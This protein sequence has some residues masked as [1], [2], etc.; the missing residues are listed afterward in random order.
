[1]G[2]LSRKWRN[3]L[4]WLVGIFSLLILMMVWITSDILKKQEVALAA[5]NDFTEVIAMPDLDGS[6]WW[7]ITL[8]PEGTTTDL[9]VINRLS[10]QQMIDWSSFSITMGS[11]T[12][13]NFL[14]QQTLT[15]NEYQVTK[16]HHSYR[17]SASRLEQVWQ[18]RYRVQSSAVAAQLVNQ[19]Q[20]SGKGGGLSVGSP[21]SDQGSFNYQAPAASKYTAVTIKKTDPAGSPLGGALIKVVNQDNQRNYGTYFTPVDGEIRFGNL[22]AG[23][24][25]LYEEQAPPGYSRITAAV[26]FYVSPYHNEV[27]VQL[28]NMP[29]PK[30]ILTVQ[31]NWQGAPAAAVPQELVVELLRAGQPSGQK[32]RLTAANQYRGVF[33]DLDSVDSEG[34]AIQ[35]QVNGEIPTDFTSEGELPATPQQNQVT[36]NFLY[37]SPVRSITVEKRWHDLPIGVVKPKTKV[38]LYRNGVKLGRNLVLGEANDFKGTF[39]ELPVFDSEGNPYHYQLKEEGLPAKFVSLKDFYDVV[40]DQVTIENRY[41]KETQT[42]KVVKEWVGLPAGKSG[43]ATTVTLFVNGQNTGLQRELSSANDY[44]AV[45]EDV[46]KATGDN[47]A[48]RYQVVESPLPADF[49]ALNSTP[50]A[51]QEGIAYLRSGYLAAQQTIEVTALWEEVTPLDILPEL[52]VVLLR[53]GQATGESRQLNNRNHYQVSF[54][55]VPLFDEKGKQ[56]HYQIKQ[57][58]TPRGYALLTEG[59]QEVVDGKAIVRNRKLKV[60]PAPFLKSPLS[61]V[62]KVVGGKGTL[63]I[64]FVNEAGMPIKK[65]MEIEGNIGS[66]FDAHKI[67]GPNYKRPINSKSAS[68]W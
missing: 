67:L 27:N 55:T 2:K 7:Q 46:E 62:T 44:Q 40:N 68:E 11:G 35:Y 32:L 9:Q 51:F 8:K 53:D 42:L 31:A 21:I 30:Q 64:Q 50:V 65:S 60:T 56:I 57:K 61:P 34:G 6:V 36:L 37:R 47:E 5:S 20:I 16:D 58:E 63:T 48:L 23:N 4:S 38:T 29:I 10:S 26:P 18:I 3:L 22:P 15:T 43:P 19:V 66:K 13:A 59:P 41:L 52:T 45:F 39:L 24:Y 14:P 54:G 25:Q 49:R 1:M 17:L 12:G 28:P 33:K